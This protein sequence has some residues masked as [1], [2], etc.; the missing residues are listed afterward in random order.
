MSRRDGNGGFRCEPIDISCQMEYDPRMSLHT[1]VLDPV[2]A[3]VRQGILGTYIYRELARAVVRTARDGEKHALFKTVGD[4]M[5]GDKTQPFAE[6]LL[7][8]MYSD[9]DLV[10]GVRVM[11]VGML[12]TI[13]QVAAYNCIDEL[14]DP[15]FIESLS[16]V[17]RDDDDEYSYGNLILKSLRV[18]ADQERAKNYALTAHLI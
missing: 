5:W 14:N 8:A 13:D 4:M 11:L 12:G 6:C 3:L 16:A 17:L 15:F 1:L 10:D 9:P 18:E 7:L 2:L